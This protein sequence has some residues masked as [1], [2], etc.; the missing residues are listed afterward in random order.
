MLSM[1]LCISE[2][3]A[4]ELHEALDKIMHLDIKQDFLTAEEF[5]TIS[6]FDDALS[7]RLGL[8]DKLGTYVIKR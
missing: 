8:V 5:N 7:F 2:S 1:K 3:L 4:S 6:L